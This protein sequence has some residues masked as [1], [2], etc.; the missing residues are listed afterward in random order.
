MKELSNEERESMNLKYYNAEIHKASFVLPE[1]ARKVSAAEM[2]VPSWF[3]CSKCNWIPL[4]HVVFVLFFCHWQ[5]LNEAWPA[6]HNQ[7]FHP[8]P[9]LRPQLNHLVLRLHLLN[10]QHGRESPKDFL[11]VSVLSYTESVILCFLP[12]GLKHVE[13]LFIFMMYW[14]IFIL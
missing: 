1:F 4:F 12:S 13:C 2:I 14:V 6:P 7:S 10:N 9:G 3:V 11:H 5:A 8:L